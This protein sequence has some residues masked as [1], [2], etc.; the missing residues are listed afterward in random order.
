MSGTTQTYDIA[1]VGA[2]ILGLSHAYQAAKRGLKAVVLERHPFA[3]GA[4]IRNFGMIWPIG[5][6][7]GQLFELALRSRQ[8][9]LD[10]CKAADIWH[11]PCG[12]VHLVT[13]ED[14]L[15]VLSEFV[16][17]GRPRGYHV[18][19]W[20]RKEACRRSPVARE[21]AVL[22][23]M[24]SATEI[25]VDSPRA[26]SGIAKWL[27]AK[28]G[29]EFRFATPVLSIDSPRV[30]VPGGEVH[31]PRVV[32]C[33]GSDFEQLYPEVY[34]KAGVHRCKLQMMAAAA[35]S[36]GWKLG[37]MIASGLTIRHYPN[38]A[39]CKSLPALEARIQR[40]QPELN[41]LGI[42][43]MMSQHMSGELIIGDS[44]EYD[45][46]I[47]PF[48]SPRID[49][50]ILAELKR[51]LKLPAWNI[52]R[53]WSGIYSKLAGRTLLSIDPAPGVRVVNA[54]AGK[55]MTMG[56]GLA[57]LMWENWDGFKL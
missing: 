3:Q 23:G 43:V 39:P 54:T 22:G 28:H 15:A 49:E 45:E 1:I 38:F 48:D 42:H 56:F 4:S 37:P 25:G 6:P 33:T 55:G 24:W 34:A 18:E 44:H 7:A 17:Y 10:V 53:R 5:Q 9:W 30:C 32:V 40:E 14:E 13:R 8:I 41:A 12:S 57:D 20:D 36:P 27:A 51:F 50:L 2:G 21:D 47:S 16:E 52:T 35:P 26:I 46:K 19:L 29:V 11:D 31:A